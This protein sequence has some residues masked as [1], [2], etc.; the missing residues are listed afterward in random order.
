MA[1][2]TSSPCDACRG[3]IGLGQ[4]SFTSECAHTFHLGCVSGEATCPVCAAKWSDT[5]ATAPAPAPAPSPAS[6][7]VQTPPLMPR[8]SSLFAGA[9]PPPY[10]GSLFGQ[11]VPPAAQKQNP[12]WLSNALPTPQQSSCSACH[13]AIGSGQASVTS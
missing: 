4:A 8:P 5:F 11:N 3:D 2:S 10:G 1:N 7:F 12:F 13:G 6:P 9:R